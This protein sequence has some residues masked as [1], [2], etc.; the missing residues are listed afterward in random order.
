M[1]YKEL[2]QRAVDIDLL[3][4]DLM[5]DLTEKEK[6]LVSE[7]G[8][9]ALF[10]KLGLS[11][12]DAHLIR[13]IKDIFGAY[14]TLEPE[15][16]EAIINKE[17][18]S[19]VIEVLEDVLLDLKKGTDKSEYNVDVIEN[20]IKRLK[21]GETLELEPD[22]LDQVIDRLWNTENNIKIEVRNNKI[23]LH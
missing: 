10:N 22:I 6:D 7:E 16:Y 15:E 9:E 4:K 18:N 12:K 1:T 23:K 2:K 20:Y 5:R 8:F 17:N 14:L 21:T 19:D 3:E 13:R 11:I